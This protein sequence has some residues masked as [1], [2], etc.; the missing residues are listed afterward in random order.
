MK[1]GND[2]DVMVH[3]LDFVRDLVDVD[4]A[5][6]SH[7]RVVAV[8]TLQRR[9]QRARMEYHYGYEG[10]NLYYMVFRGNSL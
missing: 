5:N 2:C 4:T 10:Y 6:V 3:S 1:C 8:S 7:L 9:G